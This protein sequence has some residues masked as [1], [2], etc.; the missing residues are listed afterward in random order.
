MQHLHVPVVLTHVV[1]AD[2]THR[3]PLRS[4]RFRR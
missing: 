4:S 3:K 2:R 1:D